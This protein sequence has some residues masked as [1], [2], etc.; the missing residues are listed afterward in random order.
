VGLDLAS[1]LIAQAQARARAEALPIEFLEGDA[2]ALPFP[3]SS[4]DLVASVYGVMFTP[5]PEQIVKELLRVTRPG[6]RIALANW[7][8]EG[9]IGKMFEVFQQYLPRTAAAPPSP[10]DW[11]NESIVRQRLAQGFSELQTTRRIARL[12]YPF[13]PGGTV[14]FFRQ[15]YGPTLHAFAALSPAAQ[16]ELRRDLERLQ[17]ESNMSPHPDQTEVHAEYLEIHAT[18]A[19]GA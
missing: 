15:K 19:N 14:D 8:A 13:D 7:T 1:N 12:A 4:F 11:G 10:L 2:E 9:F 6:G 5:Q 17:S 3:D 18:V 16:R